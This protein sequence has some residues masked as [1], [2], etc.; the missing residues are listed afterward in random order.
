MKWF[1]SLKKAYRIIIAVCAWLPL[2]IFLAAISGSIGADG[3]GVQ[4]WQ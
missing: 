2:V 3:E 1:I 4:L